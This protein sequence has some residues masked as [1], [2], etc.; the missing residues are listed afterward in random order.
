MPRPRRTYEIRLITP[1]FIAG[2][3]QHV[4]ELRVP[5]IRGCLRW[6]LRLA[7]H[8]A[9]AAMPGLR[10]TESEMFGS[11]GLGQRLLLRVRPNGAVTP[12]QPQYAALPFDHQYLWFSLRPERGDGKA[13]RRPAVAAGTVFTLEATLPPAVRDPAQVLDRLDKVVS[14]WVL[15]GAIGTRSRRCAGSLW[16]ASRLPGGRELPTGKDAIEDVLQAHRMS[17]PIELVVSS[18]VFGDWGGAVRAAGNHYRGRRKEVKDRKGR[19]ALPAL[20]WP[21]MGR[22]AKGDSIIVDGRETDRMASP[23]LLKVIPDGARFR[24]VL[25]TVKRPFAETVRSGGGEARIAEVI[26]EFARDFES[27]RG[28][29]PGRRGGAPRR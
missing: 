4:P 13:I 23:V 18:E 7:E 19:V 24:W 20:G 12:E 2:A 16:F 25:V 28:P 17:L 14:Q 3:D 9:G 22:A 1:A 5:E 26:G 21:I 8:G 15:F 6:W 27:A 29:E 11:T 10:R